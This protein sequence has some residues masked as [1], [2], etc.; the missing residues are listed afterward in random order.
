MNGAVRAYVLAGKCA[1]LTAGVDVRA[2][3]ELMHGGPSNSCRC[4]QGQALA[5]GEG[6]LVGRKL[7]E[8]YGA[9]AAAG[10]QQ[11]VARIHGEQR[12]A[13]VAG[14]EAAAVDG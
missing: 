11:A 4:V 2:V 10:A 14:H 3:A 6:N 1:W 5:G 9:L 7:V 13:D 8:G 12:V